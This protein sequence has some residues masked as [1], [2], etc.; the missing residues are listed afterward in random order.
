[1]PSPQRPAVGL[2]QRIARLEQVMP[3]TPPGIACGACGG[4]HC[5]GVDDLQHYAQLRERGE[6]PTV[7]ACDCCDLS[8]IAER[9]AAC[10]AA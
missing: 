4:L 1:M 7:C 2:E 3:V 5:R 10:H 6:Q 8:E 9:F